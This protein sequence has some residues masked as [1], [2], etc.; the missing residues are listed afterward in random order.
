MLLTNR[1]QPSPALVPTG[2]GAGA[3]DGRESL[4]A[5]AKS[6]YRSILRH[7]S[8]PRA[9][10]SS[11]TAAPSAHI[12]LALDELTN[13]G[14]IF[15]EDGWVTAVPYHHV[16]DTLLAEQVRILGEALDGVREAQR[17]LRIL[18]DRKSTRLN[19]SH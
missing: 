19:S 1:H 8:I 14:L 2:A 4:A 10:L 9:E 13:L 18:I 12:Q 7:G 5:H 6:L 11:L 16:V 15:S 17:R 3:R